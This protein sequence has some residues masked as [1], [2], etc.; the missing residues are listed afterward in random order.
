MATGIMKTENVDSNTC[1]RSNPPYNE[2]KIAMHIDIN[3]RNAVANERYKITE[4]IKKGDYFLAFDLSEKLIERKK[5]NINDIFLNTEIVT[6]I[7]NICFTIPADNEY[8]EKSVIMKHREKF[9][10]NI[11]NRNQ[12][13]AVALNNNHDEDID[14]RLIQNF[15]ENHVSEQEVKSIKRRY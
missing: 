14:M 10:Y 11:L 12:R 8:V 7:I 13:L 9:F 6:H 2:Y 15:E 1:R 4:S 5:H 3:E